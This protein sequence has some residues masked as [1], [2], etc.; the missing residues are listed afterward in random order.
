MRNSLKNKT[1]T[2]RNSHRNRARN[3]ETQPYREGVSDAAP[4][5]RILPTPL[6]GGSASPPATLALLRSHRH[7]E[8]LHDQHHDVPT[9][10]E[11][12]GGKELISSH[13]EFSFE[14]SLHWLAP[15]CHAYRTRV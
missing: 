1:E 5:A 3:S 8:V 9:A 4:R 14:I 15:G 7:H 10:V 12:K 11:G 2:A 6:R 13:H